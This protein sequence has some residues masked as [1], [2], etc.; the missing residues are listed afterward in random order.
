MVLSNF[1]KDGWRMST[2]RVNL[3]LNHIL[4][5]GGYFWA[6]S[7]WTFGDVEMRKKFEAP[8]KISHRD[9]EPPDSNIN[10]LR[11]N[12]ISAFCFPI[13]L[14]LIK[15]KRFMAPITP[16]NPFKL[17]D[18]ISWE[19]ND[20]FP[21]CQLIF[22]NTC[23]VHLHFSNKLLH[24]G[25]RRAYWWN[26]MKMH[27]EVSKS[28]CS[29]IKSIC[30]TNSCDFQENL[31]NRKK[32]RESCNPS[33]ATP[34]RC[35][36]SSSLCRKKPFRPFLFQFLQGLKIYKAK[37]RVIPKSTRTADFFVLRMLEPRQ[38]PFRAFLISAFA[39]L[40]QVKYSAKADK[41]EKTGGLGWK[42]RNFFH[43]V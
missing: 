26:I 15:N 40:K 23:L 19:R 42:K 36:F 21:F 11:R 12:P 32:T 43:F 9:P 29:S 6:Y 8:K 31:N 38:T 3:D 10:S 34:L 27:L 13:R 16:V 37:L 22:V 20:F 17:C 4:V 2:S 1:S 24:N 7:D 35:G 14:S 18:S 41:L 39:H 30:S 28:C 25:D 5:A 33:P